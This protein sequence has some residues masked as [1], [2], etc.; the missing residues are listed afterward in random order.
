MSNLFPAAR[1]YQKLMI[2]LD[3]EAICT[4]ITSSLGGTPGNAKALILAD[5]V[6]TPSKYPG[7][8]TAS[9]TEM[10]DQVNLFQ[11]NGGTYSFGGTATLA[12][13]AA[14]VGGIFISS[15]ENFR[16]LYLATATTVALYIKPTA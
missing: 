16:K 12:A 4:G 1:L 2:A 5:Y 3:G 11:L 6:A 8:T 7:Y 9:F 10:L 14:N 13:P 15:Q